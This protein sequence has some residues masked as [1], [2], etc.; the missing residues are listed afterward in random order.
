MNST[1]GD[2]FS[3][4]PASAFNTQEQLRSVTNNIRGGLD[5]LQARSDQFGLANDGS[6]RD[7]YTACKQKWNS[8]AS[9]MPITLNK[10]QVALGN[11]TT[12]IQS[13]DQRHAAQW[14]N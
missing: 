8:A 12:N 10:A 3:I 6:F 4:N 1:S 11:I 5:E 14:S 9:Q 13:T 2:A 7:A